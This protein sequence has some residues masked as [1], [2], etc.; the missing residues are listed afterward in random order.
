M[1]EGRQEGGREGGR[2]LLKSAWP[3]TLS[4]LVY[5]EHTPGKGRKKGG[6]EGGKGG[7]GTLARGRPSEAL[8]EGV[9][10][11]VTVFHT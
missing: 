9:L 1:K 11:L 3:H 5:T 4:R 6:R 7:R 2:D 10:S 8:T